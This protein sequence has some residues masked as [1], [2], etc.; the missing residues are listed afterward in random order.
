MRNC[1]IQ[2][3]EFAKTLR[4]HRFGRRLPPPLAAGHRIP[5]LS[6]TPSTNLTD[7]QQV[8]VTGTSLGVTGLVAVVECGNADSN[9][10]PLPGNAPT[11][12]DCYGAE[13][14]GTGTIL[15]PVANDTATTPYTVHTAGIGANGRTCISGG[16]FDCVIAMADVATL[17]NTLTIAAPISFA[18]GPTTTTSPSVTTTTSS[19]ST[20]TPSPAPAAPVQ[21]GARFTG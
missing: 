9:G 16:N 7:G 3:T 1:A 2:V 20:T 19:T 21:A 17:G 14:I 8:T 6:V 4:A 10:A 13:S 11:Q 15:V 12:A 18:G 5:S